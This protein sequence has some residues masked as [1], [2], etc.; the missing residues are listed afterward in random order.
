M[1]SPLVRAAAGLVR[2]WTTLYT[3]GLP[4]DVRDVAAAAVRAFDVRNGFRLCRRSRL[5]GAARTSALVLDDGRGGDDSPAAWSR[6]LCTLRASAG[7]ASRSGICRR[8]APFHA[9]TAAATATALRK[10]RVCP[11]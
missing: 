3:C 10:P 6:R 7:S 5:A 1:T 4:T 9:A 11:C 2:G 8:E